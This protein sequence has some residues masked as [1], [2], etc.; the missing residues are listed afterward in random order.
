MS[1]SMI[2]LRA[3]RGATGSKYVTFRGGMRRAIPFLLVAFAAVRRTVP[4]MWGENVLP[5]S[6]V[7]ANY[8]GDRRGRPR[9]LGAAGSSTGARLRPSPIA[10]AIVVR[11]A[12]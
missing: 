12:E 2:V 8:A 6:L 3:S 7:H 5:A 11:I 1:N 9:G 4:S 10:L